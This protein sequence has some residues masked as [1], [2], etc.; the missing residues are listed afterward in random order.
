MTEINLMGIFI[1]FLPFL[2]ALTLFFEVGKSLKFL[3][4]CYPD[5]ILLHLFKWLNIHRVTFEGRSSEIDCR[6]SFVV[7]GI[8]DS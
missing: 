3:A 8:V 1:A 6:I 4:S 7:I 2:T 5:V